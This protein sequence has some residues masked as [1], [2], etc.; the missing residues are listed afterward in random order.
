MPLTSF[1]GSMQQFTHIRD[2]YKPVQPAVSA[3]DEA[4]S[5][6]EMLP[7]PALQPYIYCYWQLKTNVAALEPF[8]YRVVADGCMDIFFVPG[9]AAETWL[10]GISDAY[11][12][13]PLTGDFHFAGIR[14]LPGIFPQL[15]HVPADAFTGKTENL[16]AIDPELTRQLADR[17]AGIQQPEA[18]ALVLDELLLGLIGGKTFSP[19]GRFYEALDLILRHNGTIQ[20]EKE[21]QTGISPRQL[22]R[23]FGQYV[24]DTPKAFSSIVRF[25]RIL[26]AKPSSRSLREDKLFFDA[27]YYDQSH[28][29]REFRRFYGLTPGQAWGR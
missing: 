12:E 5:Y 21:I 18:L 6:V 24:G 3:A 26:Q 4:V 7:C 16:A 1:I 19:D 20:L 14:F 10:M 13:F 9:N 11:T 17:C 8:P 25:Q 28:F 15:Y 2:L 29:I 22:R 27:G 23:M